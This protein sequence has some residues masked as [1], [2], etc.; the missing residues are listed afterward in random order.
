[1]P[2]DL[3][4]VVSMQKVILRFINLYLNFE[5]YLNFYLRREFHTESLILSMKW[6]FFFFFFETA[7]NRKAF[8]FETAVNKKASRS[9]KVLQN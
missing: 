8:F 4:Q 2:F 6:D 5:F 9:T 7:V 3:P 1:M